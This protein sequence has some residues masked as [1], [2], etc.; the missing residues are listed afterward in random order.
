M[1]GPT[2]LEF[3]G[4]GFLGLHGA[5]KPE[6]LAEVFESRTLSRYLYMSSCKNINININISIYIY[7]HT[8]I[9]KFIRGLTQ[10][11]KTSGVY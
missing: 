9:I 1:Y 11:F 2:C 10:E 5:L 4:H 3:G 7:A 8:Y 6:P